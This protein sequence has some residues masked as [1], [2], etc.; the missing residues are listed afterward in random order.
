MLRYC[1]N[2][3]EIRYES[4]SLN[5]IIDD[6]SHSVIVAYNVFDNSNLSQEIFAIDTWRAVI[7]SLGHYRK[8]MLTILP[9]IWRPGFNSQFTK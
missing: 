7:C 4:T 8:H 9:T 2:L 3:K 1:A 5:T 6:K